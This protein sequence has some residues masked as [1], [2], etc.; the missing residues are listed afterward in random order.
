MADDTTGQSVLVRGAGDVG[1]AVAALLFRAGYAVA[2]HDE[3]A[4]ATPRRGMP[5]TDAVFDGVAVLEEMTARR[6]DTVSDLHDVLVA[7]QV[8]PVTIVPLS[9]VLNARPWRI[10]IDAGLRK[11]AVPERQRGLAPLTIG[12]GPNFIAGE[13]VDLAIETAWGESL[14]AIIESGPTLALA[15]EPRLLGGTGRARFIYA[16]VAGRFETAARIGDRVTAGDGIGTIAGTPISAPQTGVIRG[17]THDGVPVA[18]A[19]KILEIDPRGDPAAAFGF[20]P[21]TTTRLD[22]SS[23]RGFR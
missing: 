17:L 15:G 20:A 18:K 6:I 5:F 22:L 4:P 13:N 3:P 10:L 7:R 12:L 8:V 9:K 11:R 1:S 23:H 2:L 19:T 21:F 14:G 16:P